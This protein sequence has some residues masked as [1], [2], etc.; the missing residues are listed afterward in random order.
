MPSKAIEVFV[1]LNAIKSTLELRH[2]DAIISCDG[3]TIEI[4]MDE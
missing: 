1:V 3:F 4:C 2:N